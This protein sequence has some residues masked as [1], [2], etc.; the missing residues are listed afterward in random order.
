M[1]SAIIIAAVAGSVIIAVSI[2]IAALLI[3][4]RSTHSESIQVVGPKEYPTSAE[5][6]P[7]DP[8]GVAVTADTPLRPNSTV[9]AF[10][11]GRWWRANVV[12]V[13]GELVTI[14]YP[15]WDSKWDE[16]V[17][18]NKLQVDTERS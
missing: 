6:V 1:T 8:S 11:Q 12:A 3:S 10:S 9:F 17:A 13:R 2:V 15:G 7:V 14:S 4:R 16:S 18:R 5:G